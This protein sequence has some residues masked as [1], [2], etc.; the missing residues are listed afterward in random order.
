MGKSRKK[1]GVGDDVERLLE[2]E[3]EKREGEEEE[4]AE[5]LA[6]VTAQPGG[7]AAEAEETEEPPKRLMPSQVPAELEALHRAPALDEAR[8]RNLR[9]RSVVPGE[10]FRAG[11]GVLQ[12]ASGQVVAGQRVT[13]VAEGEFRAERYGYLYLQDNRLSVTSPLWMD[14]E[15]MAVHWLLLDEETRPVTVKMVLQCLGDRGVVEGIK[16]K[17]IEKAAA[18]VAAGHHRCGPVLIAAGR[19]PA[20]G[21]DA[22][23]EIMLETQPA[24][25]EEGEETKSALR[26]QERQMLATRRPA[27]AGVSG[28]DVCGTVLPARDGVDQSLRPG[29]NVQVEKSGDLEAFRAAA[30]GVLRLDDDLL[31]V[32]RV[33]SIDGSVGFDT[34]DIDFSGRVGIEG[35]VSKGFSV[36]ADD[37]IT[38]TGTV[39]PGVLVQVGG[40]V[41]VGGGVVGKKTRVTTGGT[42]RAG[43]VEQARVMATGDILLGNY[44]DQAFLCAGGQVRIARGGEGPRAGSVIGGEIWGRQGVEL[45]MAGSRAGV[46]TKLVAGLMP[47]QGQHLDKLEE[48][49]DA[50]YNQL[51]RYLERFGMTQVDL[52]QIQNMIG[53]ATGPRRRLLTSTAQRLA[54]AVRLYKKLTTSQK[55][56]RKEIDAY[57]QEAEIKIFEQAYPGVVIQIGEHRRELEQADGPLCFRVRDDELVARRKD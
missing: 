43:F 19:A 52:E 36:K 20:H 23:V 10:V 50:A 12:E 48:R 22:H 49:L 54:K 6:E 21:Q 37:D 13:A 4:E 38:I 51:M 31:S 16:S 14:Q 57:I 5:L 30:T 34:G 39:E 29:D 55:Q 1:S 3:E 44:A 45:Y 26:V 28:F 35:S 42:V 24:E 47:K 33:L 27:T 8:V 40:D 11:E 7:V 2:R 15:K 9:A 32:I 25:D 17:A 53:A 41:S 46:S 18:Q 56:L